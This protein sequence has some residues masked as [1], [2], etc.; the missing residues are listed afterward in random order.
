MARL[1]RLH[2]QPAASRRATPT[3]PIAWANFSRSTVV[4]PGFSKNVGEITDV[5]R[6]SMTPP[7]STYGMAKSGKAQ[8]LDANELIAGNLAIPKRICGYTTARRCPRAD[9]LYV[10][11]DTL[12]SRETFFRLEKGDSLPKERNTTESR[13]PVPTGKAT[14]L[15]K[16]NHSTMQARGS[17]YEKKRAAPSSPWLKSGVPGAKYYDGGIV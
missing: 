13:Y 7:I 1:R 14:R 5:W 9:V 11:V 3:M 17:E 12:Y 16:S 10:N 15:R 4:A 6:N 8:S 2:V